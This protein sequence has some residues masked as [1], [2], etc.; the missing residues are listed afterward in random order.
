MLDYTESPFWVIDEE[1]KSKFGY[2]VDLE[3]VEL[4]EKSSL[5]IC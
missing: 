2:N 3:N 5:S 4:S 1:A